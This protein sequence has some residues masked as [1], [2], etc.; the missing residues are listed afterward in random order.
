M[1]E[2]SCRGVLNAEGSPIFKTK[3]TVSVSTSIMVTTNKNWSKIE[4][5]RRPFT[6]QESQICVREVYTAD[7]AGNA[8]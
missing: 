4:R 3:S 1:F 2:I 5:R 8:D 7:K 6:S